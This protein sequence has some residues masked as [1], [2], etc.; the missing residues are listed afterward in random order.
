M[1][2]Q[3]PSLTYELAYSHRDDLLSLGASSRQ[4]TI[5]VAGSF[6]RRG[7]LAGRRGLGGGLVHAGERL[8]GEVREVRQTAEGTSRGALHSATSSAN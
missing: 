7:L 6:V 3:N 5:T 4:H 2:H 1:H 8:S